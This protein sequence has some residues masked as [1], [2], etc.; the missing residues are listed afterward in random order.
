MPFKKPEFTKR[1]YVPTNLMY[2]KNTMVVLICMWH[3]VKQVPTEEIQMASVETDLKIK[4]GSGEWKDLRV[5]QFDVTET[6]SVATE[7]PE[8]LHIQP[9]VAEKMASAPHAEAEGDEPTEAGGDDLAT[10]FDEGGKHAFV[11]TAN[12]AL[13]GLCDMDAAEADEPEMDDE[14][15]PD[16]VHCLKGIRFFTLGQALC[17]PAALHLRILA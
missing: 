10:A 9:D 14:S 8:F 16:W 5:R 7:M 2:I 15:I 17:I 6:M 4:V 13:D 11:P 12:P 3:M 1:N